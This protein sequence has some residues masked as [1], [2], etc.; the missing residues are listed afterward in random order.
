[1]FLPS[2]RFLHAISPVLERGLVEGEHCLG[3]KFKRDE[4]PELI[5]YAGQSLMRENHFI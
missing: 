3:K 5:G 1:M 4:I 2:S